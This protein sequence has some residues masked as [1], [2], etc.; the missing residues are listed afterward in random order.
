[1]VKIEMIL[2]IFLSTPNAFGGDKRDRTADLLNAIREE[3]VGN[4]SKIDIVSAT[5]VQQKINF[6]TWNL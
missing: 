4:T 5:R 2:T 6:S 3:I 1:M